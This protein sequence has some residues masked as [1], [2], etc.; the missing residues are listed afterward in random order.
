MDSKIYF[1]KCVTNIHAGSGDANY[2]V[3]DKQVQRDPVTGYPTVFASGIKGALREH[4]SLEDE[5][6]ISELVPFFGSEPIKQDE[7]Q[8]KSDD[9]VKTRSVPG[10]GKFTAA[11]LL[12]IPMRVSDGGCPYAMVTTKTAL[13]QFSSFMEVLGRTSEIKTSIEALQ[14]SNSYVH[15]DVKAVEGIPLNKNN[16]LPGE[17][18]V[19]I[20][21]V[22]TKAGIPLNIPMVILDE[23]DFT[24]RIKY[25]PVMARNKLVNSESKNL[26][27]EE[28]VPHESIFWFSIMSD[29]GGLLDELVNQI[30]GKNLVELGGYATIGEGLV[31][32]NEYQ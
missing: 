9:K 29:N 24:E 28:F 30:R 3:V 12:A 16:D 21:D 1:M 17:I 31:L 23:E 19:G 13:Q 4:F 20:R 2:H 11:Q 6:L 14:A 8:G 32:L 18:P 7:T 10:K 27:Y 25:L 15:G 5:R 22:L 26:W